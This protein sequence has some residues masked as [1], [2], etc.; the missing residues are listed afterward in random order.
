MIERSGYL[1]HVNEMVIFLCN[2]FLMW[3]T[4][5]GRDF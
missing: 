5:G 2:F 1:D 3:N 4:R